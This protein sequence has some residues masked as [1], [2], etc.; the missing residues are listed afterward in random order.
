MKMQKE[1][2]KIFYSILSEEWSIDRSLLLVIVG[3]NVLTL[4]DVDFVAPAELRK[5]NI[6]EYFLCISN[7]TN[8]QRMFLSV[9]VIICALFTIFVIFVNV[10]RMD[11]FEVTKRLR[12]NPK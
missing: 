12:S 5:S 7:S 9:C 10:A 3:I 2:I 4:S 1:S 11:A 6:N 8:L